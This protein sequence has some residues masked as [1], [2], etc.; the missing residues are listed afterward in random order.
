M[1]Y[2]FIQDVN[3]IAFQLEHD[4]IFVWRSYQSVRFLMRLRRMEQN[5]HALSWTGAS[6]MANKHS[7]KYN[8]QLIA[9]A[10]SPYNIL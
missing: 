8:Q 5:W 2:I 10:N 4:F 9:I 1:Q 3:D 7:R 6:L